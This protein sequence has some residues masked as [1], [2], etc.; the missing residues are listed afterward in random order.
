MART[1]LSGPAALPLLGWRGNVMAFYADPLGTMR[2]LYLRYGRLVRWVPARPPWLFAFGPDYNRQILTDPRR[3]QSQLLLTPAPADSALQRLGSGLFA[4]NGAQHQQQRRLLQPAFHRQ[5][6]AHYAAVMARCA[7]AHIQRWHAGQTLDLAAELQHLTMQIA[8]Q[9]LFGLALEHDDLQICRRIRAWLGLAA[10]SATI[11]FPLDLP[12]HPYRQM[13][14]LSDTIDRDLRV[15]IRRRRQRPDAGDNALGTLIQAR[16]TDGSALSDDELVAQTAQLFAAGYETTANALLWTVLLLHQ[17]PSV[18]ANLQDELAG[19]LRGAAPVA[20]QL[21]QLVLLERVINESLRL[22]PPVVYAGRRVALA[23]LL[24]EQELPEGSQIFFSHFLTHRLPELYHEP[25]RFIPARWECLEPSPYAFLPFSAGPRM[26]LGAAFAMTELKTVLAVLLQ[27]V[28]LRLPERVRVDAQVRITL[29][30]RGPVPVRIG[31][32]SRP[33][34]P[35][36]LSGTLS[37]LL[38]WESS[39]QPA[40]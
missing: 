22:L 38:R 24:G 6:V 36:A 28:A 20:E 31:P 27:R 3:F 15:L 14:L 40:M 11:L 33:R 8:S 25:A 5:R 17:H 37:R 39:P 9:T 30:P 2:R 1:P 23:G 7:E 10:S 29:A 18:L 32:P 16:D 26:C 4:M 35:A 13:L 12:G 34:A 19:V 21:G